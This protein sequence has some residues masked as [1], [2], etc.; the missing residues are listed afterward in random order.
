MLKINLKIFS[1]YK[2]D[3]AFW[4]RIFGCGIAGKNILKHKLSFSE[5]NGYKKYIMIGNWSFTWLV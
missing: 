3:G 4:F 1:F 5:R 2:D